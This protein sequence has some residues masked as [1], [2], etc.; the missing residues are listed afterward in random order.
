MILL[1]EWR[2]L[3]ERRWLASSL[4][5]YFIYQNYEIPLF[6]ELDIWNTSTPFKYGWTCIFSDSGLLYLV[7]IKYNHQFFDLIFFSY[8]FCALQVTHLFCKSYKDIRLK[9]KQNTRPGKSSWVSEAFLKA[10]I[11]SHNGPAITKLLALVFLFKTTR[12]GYATLRY[13]QI[14][15]IKYYW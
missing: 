11:T 13:V 5:L 7:S 3:D 6:M 2:D 4:V 12:Y 14:S 15:T 1:E 8:A 10:M 9:N